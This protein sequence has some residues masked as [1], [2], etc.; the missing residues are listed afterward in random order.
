MIYYII[1]CLHVHIYI[2]I[3][4]YICSRKV[5]S[6]GSALSSN[7]LGYV[8]IAVS[9]I[10]LSLSLSLHELFLQHILMS[11]MHSAIARMAPWSPL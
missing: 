2:Y 3:Y 6:A 10:S 4:T 7:R 5:V 8:I 11:T 1:I 9:A